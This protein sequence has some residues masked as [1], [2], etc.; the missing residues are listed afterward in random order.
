MCRSVS[1]VGSVSSCSAHR[2][3]IVM[4]SEIKNWKQGWAAPLN[5]IFMVTHMSQLHFMLLFLW[6]QRL[7]ALAVKYT[8]LNFITDCSCCSSGP[9]YRIKL[10]DTCSGWLQ[11]VVGCKPYRPFFLNVGTKRIDWREFQNYLAL[12]YFNTL[13]VSGTRLEMMV[14]LKWSISS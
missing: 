5:N 8:M 13:K 10:K 9:H 11:A 1:P 6:R 4:L 7:V 3:K 14:G 2:L 12:G